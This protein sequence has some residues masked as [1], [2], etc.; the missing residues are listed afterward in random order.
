MKIAGL[1]TYIVDEGEGEVVL[2]LHGWGSDHKDFEGSAKTIQQYMRTI[3]IDLWGFGKSSIP[4]SS[5]S[6]DN[7]V[8]QL[9]KL[10]K[11]LNLKNFHLVGHSF[12]GKVAAKFCVQYPTLCKSLI[13]V[14][15][16]G[17]I[18]KMSFLQKK[19]VKT[20]KKLKKL[21]EEGKMNPEVLESF[22]SDDYKKSGQ[23][24]RKIMVTVV[25]ENCEEDFKNIKIPTLIVWG[26][27]DKTTPLKMGKRVKKLI[28]G[29]KFVIFN[30]GHF[31]HIENFINFNRLCLGF[32]EDI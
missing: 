27:Q 15:T 13:L 20:Y 6:S 29:S 11:K 8:N 23:T 32:W 19:R 17:L 28:S 24:M 14:S 25:N 5:W 3:N 4:P 2:F 30:G 10:V 21:V 12:G 7:Y 31:S 9:Y 26:R 1:E 22:G 16:A 18:K